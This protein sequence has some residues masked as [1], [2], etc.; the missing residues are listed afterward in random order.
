MAYRKDNE[1]QLTAKD[2]ID[3]LFTLAHKLDHWYDVRK[4]KWYDVSVWS[5]EDDTKR[6]FD[7]MD[8]GAIWYDDTYVAPSEALKIV[9]DI[10]EQQRKIIDWFDEVASSR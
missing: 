2:L 8:D 4:I 5:K 1:E 9:L 3:E 7:I 6:L 10:Q